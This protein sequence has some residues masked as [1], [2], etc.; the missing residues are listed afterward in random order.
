MHRAGAGC[1]NAHP[2]MFV[3]GVRK[4][5]RLSSIAGKTPSFETGGRRECGKLEVI[6]ELHL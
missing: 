1:V 3:E 5:P 2:R 4:D 6:Q